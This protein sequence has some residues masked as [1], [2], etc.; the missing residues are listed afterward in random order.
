[1][2]KAAILIVEDEEGIREMLSDAARISGYE[3]ITCKDGLEALNALRKFP[4]NLIISDVNM[5]NMTGFDML[6]KIRVRGDNT[7]IIFLTARHEKQDVTQGLRLGADDYITKPFGLEELMLRVEAVLRRSS[8][9]SIAPGESE[10]VCGKMT[11][12][13]EQF[14]VNL[15][16]LEL[17][18]SPTEFSL[19]KYLAAHANRVVRKETLLEE[20]WGI[21]FDA[22]TSVLDTYISYLRKKIH[23]DGFEPIK[24]VRGIGYKFECE[25]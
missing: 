7:P 4:V 15:D 19:M 8:P 21:R 6:E 1:M 11:I 18:L 3:A 14:T 22:N 25:S 17:S 10:I 23:G 5:P 12:N 2:S 20:I 13:C 9:T 16:G 24:T